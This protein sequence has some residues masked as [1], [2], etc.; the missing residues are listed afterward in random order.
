MITERVAAAI[1]WYHRTGSRRH[2]LCAQRYT[3]AAE[4]AAGLA[5]QD[6]KPPA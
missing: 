6:S 2:H 3:R 4:L 1:D 5:R